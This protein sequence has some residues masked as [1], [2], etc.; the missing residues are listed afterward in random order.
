M[1]TL[2]TWTL[3]KHHPGEGNAA[4]VKGVPELRSWSLSLG[5]NLLSQQ[6]SNSSPR[7]RTNPFPANST[8]THGCPTPTPAPAS[9][10]SC[11]Y[12]ISALL[13]FFF[14][15]LLYQITPK[16]LTA[17]CPSTFD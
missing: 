12:H 15:P 10:P 11:A 3:S 2:R 4:C 16:S 7:Q 8:M 14:L 9:Q 5:A 17:F 1:M 13:F 6:S